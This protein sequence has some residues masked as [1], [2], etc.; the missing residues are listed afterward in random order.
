[1]SDVFMPTVE[2]ENGPGIRQLKQVTV[3]GDDEVEAVNQLLADGWR[4]VSIGHRSDATIYVLGRE[5]KRQ[6]P[7]TGF[8]HPE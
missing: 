5:E 8:L 7:R 6:K 1:M 2:S 4:L 3:R